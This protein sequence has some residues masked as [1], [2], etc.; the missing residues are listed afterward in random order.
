MGQATTYPDEAVFGLELLGRL[1]V[2]V[3]EAEASG[4]ASTEV[5]AELEDED[6][7]GILH[8]VHLS[9]PL[10]ELRLQ[11]QAITRVRIAQRTRGSRSEGS[12]ARAPH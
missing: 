4:L 3:D 2:I 9:Q 12:D 6:A 7:V 1:E 8:L 11:Y 10:L 5:G